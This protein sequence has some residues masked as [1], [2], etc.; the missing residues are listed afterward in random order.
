[1][2]LIIDL[3]Q[4]YLTKTLHFIQTIF[5]LGPD[6]NANPTVICRY[7]KVVMCL[8][9][10]IDYVKICKKVCSHKNVHIWK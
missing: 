2:I 1:M 3:F 6:N 5:L 10:Y 9:C 8:L 4:V 7:P